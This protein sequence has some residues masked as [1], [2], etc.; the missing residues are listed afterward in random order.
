[1]KETELRPL[2]FDPPTS[3]GEKFSGLDCDTLPYSL[4]Y[5]G[6]DMGF[7]LPPARACASS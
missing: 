5:F 4:F 7:S 6:S 2:A 3:E 1:V